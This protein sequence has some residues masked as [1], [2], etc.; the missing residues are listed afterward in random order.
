MEEGN[1][2]KT[3]EMIEEIEKYSTIYKINHANA[4]WGITFYE[5]PEGYESQQY[6]PDEY[7]TWRQYLVTYKYYDTLEKCLVEELN[8]LEALDEKEVI[9]VIPIDF[10]YSVQIKEHGAYVDLLRYGNSWG[11]AHPPKAWLAVAYTIEELRKNLKTL[12]DAAV[13][14]HNG[15]SI[16]YEDG[17]QATLYENLDKALKEIGALK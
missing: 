9:E 3:N 13:D 11:V 7:E 8:R 17:I 10:K 5:P 14:L 2:M 12:E 15:I 1:R 6:S 4:G 16:D